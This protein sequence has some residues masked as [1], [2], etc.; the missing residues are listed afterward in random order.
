MF[1]D[2][3]S[4][5][6][7]LALFSRLLAAAQPDWP[8]QTLQPGFVF[9]DGKAGNAAMDLGL[10]DFLAHPEPP[11]VFTQGST[12]V[13]APGG[14]YSVSVEAAARLGRRALLLGAPAGDWGANV[15]AATYAPYAQVFPRAAINV[16]QGGSGTVGEALR[17]GRPQLIVPFGWDQPDNGMRVERLGAG[18]HLPRTAYTVSS[19]MVA[20][21]RL[22]HEA[23]FA[24]RAARAA[25]EMQAED[26]VP[27]ACDALE[28]LLES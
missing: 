10:E 19:A 7:V 14:F 4:P 22:L 3:F 5:S 2:K 20:L 16:H 9:F 18:I 13:H 11:I 8:T 21:D 26:A 25:R 12:A 1:R 15:Y 17:A 23:H 28:A 27:A 6:L 24:E